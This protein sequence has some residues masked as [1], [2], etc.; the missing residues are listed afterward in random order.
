MPKDYNSGAVFW[1]P[2][3]VQEARDQLAK[4]EAEEEALRLQKDEKIKA[5]E[6]KKAE[7]ACMLEERWRTKAA[8]KELRLQEQQLKKAQREEAKIARQVD[9][10][11]KNDIKKVKK[12]KQK[13]I[14]SITIDQ[15]DVVDDQA[16]DVDKEPS[17]TRSRSGRQIHLPQRFCM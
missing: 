3:K 16:S 10:Q 11:L 13:V 9:E 4:K 6:A 5:R 2:N 15:E 7:K 17:L 14:A 1:S 8:T 12:G